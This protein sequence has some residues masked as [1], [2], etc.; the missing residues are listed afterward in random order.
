MVF[1]LTGTGGGWD[2]ADAADFSDSCGAGADKQFKFAQDSNFHHIGRKKLKMH[3][4]PLLAFFWFS[5]AMDRI[6]FK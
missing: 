6:F 4:G 3:H 2:G 5:S 1:R